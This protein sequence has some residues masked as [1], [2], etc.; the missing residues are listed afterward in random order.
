VIGCKV[1]RKHIRMFRVTVFKERESK[2]YDFEA[3]SAD[4]AMEIVMEIRKGME[5]SKPERL[6]QFGI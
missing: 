2:R 5:G 3:A 6:L 1:S 4:E